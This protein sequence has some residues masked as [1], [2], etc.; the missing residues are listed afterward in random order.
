[1][2]EIGS[3]TRED[4]DSGAETS[5]DADD[6]VETTATENSVSSDYKVR[7]KKSASS[8]TGV[9]G[10]NTATSGAALGVEG[11]TDS[12]DVGATGVHG[13]ATVSGSAAETVG[14]KGV[15]QADGEASNS[16]HPVGV[17]G[18]ATGSDRTFGVW[19]EAPSVTGT[20]MYARATPDSYER[21]WNSSFPTGLTAVTTYSSATSGLDGAAAV[22]GVADAGEGEAHGVLGVHFAPEGYAVWAYGDSKTEGTHTVG[23]R[24][25]ITNVGLSAYLSSNYPVPDSTFETIPFDTTTED[26]FGGYDTSSGVYTVQQAGD[27]H[28]DFL[29]DWDD[30]FAEGDSIEY[31]LLINGSAMGGLAADTIVPTRTDPSRCFSRTLFGLSAGDTIEVEI[32]QQSGGEKNITGGSSEQTYLTVAKVG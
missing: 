3:G 25:D 8:G 11:V 18:R 19:G 24:V 17:Y 30:T 7:G 21:S 15:T 2:T 26:H 13:E 20:A 6:G 16:I 9:L 29:I 5:S 1:M 4:H 14:V 22:E 12:G 23:G 10:H 32:Y 31:A 27:Y 28:V